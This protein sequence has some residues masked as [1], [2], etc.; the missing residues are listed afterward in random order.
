[1]RAAD[2]RGASLAGTLFL[3]Q[4]Q[5]DAAKGDAG[6]TVPPSLIRPAHW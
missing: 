3:T 5:L 6:T 2:I 1:L 4:P